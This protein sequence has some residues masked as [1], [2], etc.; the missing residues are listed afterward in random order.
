MATLRQP[1]RTNL[2]KHSLDLNKIFTDPT[3]DSEGKVLLPTGFATDISTLSD[4]TATTFQDNQLLKFSGNTWINTTLSTSDLSDSTEI[5]KL[6]SPEFSGVPKAPTPPVLT[7]NDTIATTAYVHDYLDSSATNALVYQGSVS[8][9]NFSATLQ[10][11]SKGSFYKISS[12]GTALDG[13]EYASGDSIIINADMG[14]AYS[15]SKLDK[16]NNTDIDTTDQILVSYNPQN[17]TA[18]ENA[19]LT[20]HISAIDNALEASFSPNISQETLGQ[21]LIYD[22]QVWV[23]RLVASTDLSDSA[24]LAKLNSPEFTGTPT[25]TTPDS[26]DNSTRV[27]TTAYVDAAIPDV[28]LA[29]TSIAEVQTLPNQMLYTTAPNVYAATAITSTARQFLTAEDPAAQRSQLQ[30]GSAALLQAGTAPLNV[31]QLDNTRRLPAVDGSALL[32]LPQEP[33]PSATTETEGVIE[34]ATNLEATDTQVSNKALVPSN[35]PAISLSSFHNDLDIQEASPPL[36][37]IASLATSS[38]EILITTD[39]DQ[40]AAFSISEAG[41]NILSA[42]TPIAQR[43]QLDLGSAALSGTTDF[44]PSTASLESLQ[45]VTLGTLTDFQVLTYQAGSWVNSDPT[46]GS[47]SSGSPNI[48]FKTTN[49]YTLDP[50]TISN[51]I[52]L[53]GAE[54]SNDFTVTFPQDIADALSTSTDFDTI[55]QSLTFWVGRRNAGNINFAFYYD[56]QTQNPAFYRNLD[57]LNG[58]SGYIQQTTVSS[59]QFVKIVA[60]KSSNNNIKFFIESANASSFSGSYDDLTDLPANSSYQYQKKSVN[61]TAQQYY[62]YS[63]D[64]SSRAILA[65]LPLL[66]DVPLGSEIRFKL[67]DATNT[68]TINTSSSE[69]IDGQNQLNINAQYTSVTLIAGEDEWELIQ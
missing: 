65:S 30:L 7:N 58:A 45:N 17:Y 39:Q 33:H 49:S 60:Y 57:V 36:S 5:A 32:N 11:A 26:G 69:T 52:V 44:L 2:R 6:Q 68:F 56:P 20:V 14:G 46:G 27:A 67:V 21:F 28:D 16:I 3:L 18:N 35:L 63:V 22:G 25:A 23:N 40:Y 31:L 42:A 10:N 62:H 15:D 37:S 8:V 4:V 38:N 19:S 34:T 66:A 55:G 41:K 48:I 13:R 47:V 53:H 1:R 50:Q 43:A 51:L 9:V 12:G 24:Q 59:G 29:L 64:T 61:F 54:N